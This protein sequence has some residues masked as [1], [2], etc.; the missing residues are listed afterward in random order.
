[1]DKPR[2][3]HA[4]WTL[5]RRTGE[6]II[7]HALASGPVSTR[8]LAQRICD[9]ELTRRTT[10]EARYGHVQVHH[11][12]VLERPL[13]ASAFWDDCYDDAW[14]AARRSGQ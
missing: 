7:D 4:M 9:A 3:F 12:T 11:F 6:V 5:C 14:F 2:A 8:E 1:M 10:E 13:E